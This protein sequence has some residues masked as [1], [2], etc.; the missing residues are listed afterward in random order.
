MRNLKQIREQKG[1][2]QL[3]AAMAL[4]IHPAVLSRWENGH[5]VPSIEVLP[6]IQALY[7]LTDSE[8]VKLIKETA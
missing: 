7:G 8:L 6:E 4:G 3:Q 2:T 5:N 1:L